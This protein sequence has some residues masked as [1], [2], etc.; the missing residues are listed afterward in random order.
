MAVCQPTT[1]RYKI[2]PPQEAK[3]KT[4]GISIPMVEG[5]S[6]LGGY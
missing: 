5:P 1:G 3:A 6:R 2:R 4:V